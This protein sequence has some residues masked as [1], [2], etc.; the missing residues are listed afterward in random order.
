M[1]RNYSFDIIR[2][3]AMV[4][5]IIMHSPIQGIN[6]PGFVLST[7]SFIT[8]PG[9]GLFF[10]LSGA[11]LLGNNMSQKVFLKHRFSKIIWPTIFGTVVYIIVEYINNPIAFDGL[12]KIIFSIPFEKQGHGILW[13]MYTLAGLYLLTP[14]MSKWLKF[15]SRR[16]VEFYLL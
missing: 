15:A 10:M 5:I 16:D 3:M 13:F 12:L 8:A 11:L 2:I 7:I 14:I 1:S 4:L 6:T 9:I